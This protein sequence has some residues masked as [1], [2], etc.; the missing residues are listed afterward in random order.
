MKVS[1]IAAQD[2]QYLRGLQERDPQILTDIYDRFFP[3]FD[4]YIC[5]RGG[6]EAD[7]K[8]VFQDAM[9]VLFRKQ[10]EKT[11]EL[12]SSFG[13][14]LVAVGKRIWLKKASRR[15]K[16]PEQPLHGI[17]IPQD[18]EIDEKL[19]R[20]EQHRLFRDKLAQL[21][22]DCKKVLR[23]FFMGTP[24]SEI[25]TEMGYTSEGYARKRKFKCKQKLTKLIKS[26]PRFEEIRYQG[27]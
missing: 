20:T 23:L 9:V 14:F 22:E 25:A 10:Q 7:A 1:K 6:D 13:T 18:A 11:F 8:D 5:N 19:E 24:M 26:D 4:R 15:V 21:G 16:R 3:V 12:T 2:Q 17:D 27:R